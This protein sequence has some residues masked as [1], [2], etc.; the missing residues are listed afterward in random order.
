[1]K[2]FDISKNAVIILK[3]EQSAFTMCPEWA[4]ARQ[5]NNVDIDHIATQGLHCFPRP[6]Y[7]EKKRP[8]RF[9]TVVVK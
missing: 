4:D 3:F 1:M 5:A 7:P 2:T 9:S 8:S 6:V